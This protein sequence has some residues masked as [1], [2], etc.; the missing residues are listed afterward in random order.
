MENIN[1]STGSKGTM[2]WGK[3][4]QNR[5]GDIVVAVSNEDEVKVKTYLITDSGNTLLLESLAN[6]AI[7]IKGF[8][9]SMEGGSAVTL[10]LREDTDGALKYTTFL[11]TTGDFIARDLS[12]VFALNANAPLYIYASGV[13]NVHVTIEYVGPEDS[14]QEGL[15]LTDSLSIAE[16]I[17]AGLVAET[18]IAIL[19]DDIAIVDSGFVITGDRSLAFEDSLSVAEVLGNTITLSLSDSISFADSSVRELTIN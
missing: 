4:R 3:F 7:K 15:D 1:K 5:Q 17:S 6:K 8:Q 14:V 2:E 18:E 12:H 13:C 11:A 10:S 16:S 19:S 9:Y